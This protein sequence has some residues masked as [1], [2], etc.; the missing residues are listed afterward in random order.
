MC[1]KSILGAVLSIKFIERIAGIRQAPERN[2][3]IPSGNVMHARPD[4]PGLTSTGRVSSTDAGERARTDK[5]RGSNAISVLGA[6]SRLKSIER[7]SGS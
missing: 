1:A 7:T 5:E 4:G 3:L 2:I 6:L